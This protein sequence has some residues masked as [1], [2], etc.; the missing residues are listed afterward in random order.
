[1]TAYRACLAVRRLILTLSFTWGEVAAV[2]PADSQGIAIGR[3]GGG[4][5]GGD[6]VGGVDACLVDLLLCFAETRGH[7]GSTGA[8]MTAEKEENSRI[9][10]AVAV[11]GV[12][13]ATTSPR[14][15][16]DALIVLIGAYRR[17]SAIGRKGSHN[18]NFLLKASLKKR[19]RSGM[20]G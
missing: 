7:C 5:G 17:I 1:M 10:S 20:P 3:R 14:M 2:F 12:C 6:G 19:R 15:T 16:N 8:R 13:L 18:E 4:G 9:H 11:R